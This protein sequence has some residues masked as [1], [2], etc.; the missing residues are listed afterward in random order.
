MNRLICGVNGV[1]KTTLCKGIINFLDVHHNG[2][3]AIYHN[4]DE[5]GILLP[6]SLIRKAMGDRNLDVGPED[7]SIQKLMEVSPVALASCRKCH[8]LCSFSAS[9]IKGFDCFSA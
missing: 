2:V 9:G 5:D 8:V 6:S 1:G 4:C 7:K 3:F